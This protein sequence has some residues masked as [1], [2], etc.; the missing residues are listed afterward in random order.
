[1][2][3]WNDPFLAWLRVVHGSLMIG[4]EFLEL[5]SDEAFCFFQGDLLVSGGG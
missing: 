5:L 3:G 1:M 2:I 4:L